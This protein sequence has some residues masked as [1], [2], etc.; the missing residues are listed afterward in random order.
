M[1]SRIIVDATTLVGK[2]VQRLDV[3][4]NP[5]EEP[6]CVFEEDLECDREEDGGRE[7]ELQEGTHGFGGDGGIVRKRGLKGVMFHHEG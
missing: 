1:Q 5:E 3:L 2:L 4:S 6:Y 7:A